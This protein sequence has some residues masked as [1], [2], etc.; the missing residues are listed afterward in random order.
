MAPIPSSY[1][2]TSLCVLKR[3]PPLDLWTW[4]S[5][6]PSSNAQWRHT[7]CRLLRIHWQISQSP[8]Y[9]P[10]WSEFSRWN[11]WLC[12]V[13]SSPGNRCHHR[14]GCHCRSIGHVFL[15]PCSMGGV[16][17]FLSL[18]SSIHP[19]L[20]SYQTDL[21]ILGLLLLRCA[22]VFIIQGPREVRLFLSYILLIICCVQFVFLVMVRIISFS[23]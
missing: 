18:G 16:R 19:I 6:L 8:R 9:S 21:K 22:Y 20:Y 13:R 7:W 15:I 14:S 5:W 4:F 1:V 11:T 17:R 3:I 2:L 10:L 23:V 12:R